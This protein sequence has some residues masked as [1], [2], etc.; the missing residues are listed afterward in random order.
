MN[1][2]DKRKSTAHIDLRLKFRHIRDVIN[3][4]RST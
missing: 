2:N 4:L 1:R 3:V